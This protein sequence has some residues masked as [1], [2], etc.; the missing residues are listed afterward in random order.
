[1]LYSSA[2]HPDL[3]EYVENV[4][5]G[6][7][8]AILYIAL[9]LYPWVPNWLAHSSLLSRSVMSSLNQEVPKSECKVASVVT[10]STG[11]QQ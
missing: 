5:F 8:N 6:G 4:S 11:F 3:S 2:P 1:M 9:P 7:I 10:N